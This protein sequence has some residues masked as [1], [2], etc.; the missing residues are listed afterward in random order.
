MGLVLL[1]LLCG[2][3]RPLPLLLLLVR[4]ST[5]LLGSCVLRD[6]VIASMLEQ[7]AWE[8]AFGESKGLAFCQTE[9]ETYTVRTPRSN[10]DYR[11]AKFAYQYRVPPKQ[12]MG[13]KSPVRM[14][15]LIFPGKSYGP[16][17]HG[18]EDFISQDYANQLRRSRRSNLPPFSNPASPTSLG[19]R[20]ISLK[21][22][23][24]K[25]FPADAPGLREGKPGDSK[26]EV[27]HIF[28]GKGPDCVANPFRTVPR[29]R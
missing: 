28:F 19:E 16:G 17:R 20:K 22:S 18:Y 1:L 2:G 21:F 29:R 27:S 11:E 5:D 23:S 13:E 3:L 8:E 10:A 24:H 7:L 9:L 12:F 26:P 4:S 6:L 14:T 15:L 25:V